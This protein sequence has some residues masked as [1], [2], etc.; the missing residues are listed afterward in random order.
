[1][2]QLYEVS[3]KDGSRLWV[4]AVSE[5]GAIIEAWFLAAMIPGYYPVVITAERIAA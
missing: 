2:T 5:H 4:P 3:F 1:M